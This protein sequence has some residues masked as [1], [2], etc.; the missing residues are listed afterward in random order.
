VDARSTRGRSWREPGQGHQVVERVVD[1]AV[2]QSGPGSGHEQRRRRDCRSGP[3]PQ[4][5]V[6][7]QCLDGA[8][9]QGQLP[10]LAE[11]AVPHH[12]PPDREI[13]IVPI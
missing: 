6:A 7:P 2:E 10:G 4:P 11:L 12:H 3:V 1:V 9:M 8:G 13:N 5:L